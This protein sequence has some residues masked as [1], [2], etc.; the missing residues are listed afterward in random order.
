MRGSKKTRTQRWK[1]SSRGRGQ[2]YSFLN[3][4]YLEQ[5]HCCLKSAFSGA[6]FSRLPLT[7]DWLPFSGRSR[8]HNNPPPP[9]S[10]LPKSG[11]TAKIGTIAG[12]HDTTQG[13]C[14][15]GE[16]RGPCVYRGVASS[17]VCFKARWLLKID[18]S[19]L[20]E[21]QVRVV[22]GAVGSV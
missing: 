1:S 17:C 10:Q 7:Q 16:T 19:R 8:P 11:I 18:E 20:R 2:V 21:V 14:L 15:G 4:N 5:K 13:G 22:Y 9:F 3:L 6:F 12:N